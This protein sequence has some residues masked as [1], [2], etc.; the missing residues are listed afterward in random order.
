[1]ANDPGLQIDLIGQVLSALLTELGKEFDAVSKGAGAAAPAAKQAAAASV[2]L[3]QHFHHLTSGL[4]NTALV[5]GFAFSQLS[6]LTG[7]IQSQI[8]TYVAL[9]SPAAM[10]Q[11]ERAVRDLNASIG[12]AMLPT[13][14]RFRVIVR[15]LGDTLASGSPQV[16]AMVAGLAAAGVAMVVFTA[17]IAALV[18]VVS[19]ASGGSTIALTAAIG[20]LVAG[21]GTAA[22]TA[23]AFSEKIDGFKSAVYSV[24]NVLSKSLEELGD[25]FGRVMTA[26]RPVLGALSEAGVSFGDMLP[27]LIRQGVNTVIPVVTTLAEVWAGLLPSMTSI[28]GAVVAFGGALMQFQSAVLQP[29]LA[30]VSVLAPIV[31]LLLFPLVQAAGLFAGLGQVLAVVASVT[32]AITS[33]PLQILSAVFNAI[34][35]AVGSFFSPLTEAFSGLKAALG[36]LFSVAGEVAS[37]IGPLI[38]LLG[39]E[40]AGAFRDSGG[41][42]AVF[43]DRLRN[44]LYYVVDAVRDLTAFFVRLARQL[45][46][47]FGLP[48]IRGGVK[49]DS[50]IG[51]ATYD[52]TTSSIE[53]VIRRTQEAAFSQGRGLSAA[54]RTAENTD[55]MATGLDRLSGSVG[56]LVEVI[57]VYAEAVGGVLEAIGNIAGAAAAPAS[58]VGGIVR[59]NVT[60]VF[61]AV[62]DVRDAIDRTV[63]V[64]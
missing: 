20:G 10:Q 8:G 2:D 36:D 31:K 9:Y 50:S 44:A 13:F 63:S 1:M 19:I 53:D 55:R 4:Q 51:K 23:G 28:L 15:A 33:G 17:S 14:E 5:A 18:T 57:Q 40:L 46:E 64:R 24:A 61:S 27:R 42:F 47:F 60:N 54:D 48:E 12:E 16:R 56:D 26:I 62:S 21:L 3:G 58:L 32:S 49:P 59:N 30:V 52:T 29:I 6:Q 35:D 38:R 22:V 41:L 37:A 25:G 39:A 43:L 45:R 11:F 7:A 34:G